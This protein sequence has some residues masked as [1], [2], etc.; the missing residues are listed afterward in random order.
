MQEVLE[1]V[2]AKTA[3]WRKELDSVNYFF[4]PAKNGI[5]DQVRHFNLPKTIS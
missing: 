3:V 4:E 2:Q 5:A 1:E